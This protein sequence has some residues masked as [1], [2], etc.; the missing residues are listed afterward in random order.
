MRGKLWYTL[1]GVL[2]GYAVWTDVLDN[3]SA[4]LIASDSPKPLGLGPSGPSRAIGRVLRQPCS[5]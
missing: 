4:E 5:C 2:V 3:G 1:V